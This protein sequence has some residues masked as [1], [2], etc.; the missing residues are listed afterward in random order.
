MEQPFPTIMYIDSN[1]PSFT[2]EACPSF[3]PQST[4]R[5]PHNAVYMGHFSYYICIPP[6][7]L[8]LYVFKVC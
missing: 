7:T 2:T 4:N 1:Q 3:Q 8:T 5:Q 6:P